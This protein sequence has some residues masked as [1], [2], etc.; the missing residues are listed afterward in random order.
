[1]C[2]T[3]ILPFVYN[4]LYIIYSHRIM[5]TEQMIK[6]INVPK[7]DENNLRREMIYITIYVPTL[8]LQLRV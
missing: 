5:Y 7:N 4:F 2:I 6:M 3:R 1:M 8:L